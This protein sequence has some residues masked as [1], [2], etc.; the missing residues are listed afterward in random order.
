MGG[1]FRLTPFATSRS[2]IVKPLSAITE[3]P[4]SRISSSPLLRV[5]SLSEMLPPCNVDTKLIAPD[6]VIP[7]SALRV[8]WFL[9]ELNVSCY[10]IGL[11]GCSIEISVAS[12][13]TRVV[14]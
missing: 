5:S 3:S 11:E 12:I 4:G 13:P 1:M 7:I 10:A 14:G 6:G 9:Y 8:L 2:A